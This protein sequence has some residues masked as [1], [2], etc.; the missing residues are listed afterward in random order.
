[1]KKTIHLPGLNGLRAIAAFGV[2]FSH[3]ALQLKSFGVNPYLFGINPDGNPNGLMLAT[4][5]VSIFFSLSGFLITYL[6]LHERAI[7][8]I[9]IK[10]FYIRRILRIWPLYYLYFL[11]V[12]ITLEFFKI[13]FPKTSVW[14]YLFLSANIPFLINQNILL[15]DH[16]WSL[17][18]EEQ[19]YALWP[20]LMKISKQNIL[21]FSVRL[22]IGLLLL[23]LLFRLVEIKYSYSL[24]INI[25]S[26]FRFQ[27]MLI[28]AV[29]A[30]LYYKNNKILISIAT[31]I[32][33]Q[34]IS[35]IIIFLVILNIYHLVSVLDQEI[36]C[37]I[38]VFL[39]IGQSNKKNRIINL[40]IK[41]LDFLGKISYGI[42]VI[43]PI[44]IFFIAKLWGDIDSPFLKNYFVIFG[45]VSITT[46]FVAYISYNYFEKL[47]LKLKSNYT[48]VKSSSTKDL[49]DI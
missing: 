4:Y 9:N 42:Y 3:L 13:D 28:G 35:W 14:F 39:I 24:P 11:I 16:Y 44:I 2:V 22:L 10:N 29:G 38:A 1:M 8:P 37:V 7:K 21:K 30:M 6:L 27:C 47:F 12:I 34:I 32:I 23:K 33:T 46:I 20:W 19:F 18:I 48:T 5:G 36:V 17:G 41:P 31:N 45:T 26:V 25:L 49:R 43:H 15:V 40:D